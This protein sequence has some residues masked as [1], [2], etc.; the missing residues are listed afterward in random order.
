[1]NDILGLMSDLNSDTTSEIDPTASLP[2]R[3]IAATLCIFYGFAKL[4]GSQFTV[5]DSELSRPLGQVSG[6]WLTWYYFGYSAAYGTAIALLQILAGILLVVPRTAL[7]GALVL[8]PIAVNIVL[9]DVFFGVDLDGTLAAIVLLGCVCVTI[10][11]YAPRLKRAVLLDATPT[12]P[13]VR[14]LIG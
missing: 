3:W 14:A 11:M 4:N 13:T 12:R 2:T 7:L 10:S 6:F 5:L 1:M 9:V 8:L